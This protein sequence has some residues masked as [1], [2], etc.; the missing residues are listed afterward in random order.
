MAEVESAGAGGVEATGRQRAPGAGR[1]RAEEK[2]PGLKAALERLLDPTTRGDP[3]GPLR[4]TTLSASH[5]SAALAEQ[6]RAASERTVNRLLHDLGYSLQSNR[7]TVEGRQHPD[8]DRQFR[9]VN[10][11]AT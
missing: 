6:G 10:R 9:H 5:L 11:K 4:W 2:D 7:K 1:K 3:E 8:R